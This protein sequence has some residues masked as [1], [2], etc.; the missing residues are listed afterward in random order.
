MITLKRTV[1]FAPVASSADIHS[2]QIEWF[3]NASASIQPIQRPFKPDGAQDLGDIWRRMP[4]RLP[5]QN[6]HLAKPNAMMWFHIPLPEAYN[7]ADH[8]GFDNEALDVGVQLDA[9]GNS[10]HNSGFFYNGIKEAFE[11]DDASNEEIE[12]FDQPK[13]AEV[14]VLSHGHCHITDRC[15]RSD[16][17]WYVR[18]S[19]RWLILLKSQ[20]GCAL[21]GAPP[22]LA[23]VN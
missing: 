18:C 9:A 11:V 23:T 22:T 3:L 4:A 8:T 17:I 13:S 21:T 16:G 2:S 20:P 7:P 10:P 15:R 1:D 6:T 5:R 19:C 14:K 12:W